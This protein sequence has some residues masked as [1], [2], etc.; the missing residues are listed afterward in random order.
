MPSLSEHQIHKNIIY[1]TIFSGSRYAR[2][3]MKGSKDPN[4]SKDPNLQ[5]SLSQKMAR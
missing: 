1:T 2:K 4:D 5:K 3:P